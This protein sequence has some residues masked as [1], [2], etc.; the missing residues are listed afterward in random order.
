[1]LGTQPLLHQAAS[2]GAL[3]ESP[4]AAPQLLL[5]SLCIAI[6]MCLHFPCRQDL[7]CNVIGHFMYKWDMKGEQCGLRSISS[8]ATMKQRERHWAD[9]DQDAGRCRARSHLQGRAGLR[10]HM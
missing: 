9:C 4:L 3:Q 2:Q 8:T 5:P 1:M 6:W 7:K 10:A